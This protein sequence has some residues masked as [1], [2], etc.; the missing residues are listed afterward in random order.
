[1]TI[2]SGAHARAPRFG[3]MVGLVALLAFAVREHFVLATIVDEPIRGDVRDYIAY[4]WNLVTH[5]VYSGTYPPEIPV[6]DAY[7]LPGYA[8]LLAAGMVFWPQDTGWDQLQGWYTF[9]LQ[10]QVVL[11]TLTAVLAVLTA[12]RWLQPAWAVFAGLLV[13]LWPH[14]VAATGTLLSEVTFGFFL[15]L[16]CYAFARA[17]ESRR[18]AWYAVAGGA[19]GYA[20]L[21]NPLVLFFP[22]CLA[23]FT[24]C[25]HNKRGGAWMLAVFLVPVVAFALRGTLLTENAKGSGSRAKTNLVQGSWPQY[26]DAITK[27]GY[28]NARAIVDEMNAEIRT[29]SDSTPV[30]LSRIA[31]RVTEDP[32]RYARWYV[33][34]KPWLLWDWSIRVGSGGIYVLDV[35]RSPFD[36]AGLFRA[37]SAA[38]RTANPLLSFLTLAAV[39]AVP[40]VALRRPLPAPLTAVAALC[41][42]FTAMHALLQAEP[43]YAI[44]YRPFEALL[45]ASAAAWLSSEF[46]RRT[47]GSRAK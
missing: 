36:R 44:S 4:A 41:L 2:A 5:G 6:P 7:R 42:Y 29:L 16:G 12:R 13:A 21:V 37:V 38:Y 40:L 3:L 32:I 18:G 28:P 11:G 20:Y 1:M 23:A 30:G 27:S 24:F 17:W 31:A 15:M 10:V 43:R 19:F 9:V 14:H 26:H 33:F 47:G 39:L 35:R 22:I 8:W 46:L 45:V 25:K 34:E